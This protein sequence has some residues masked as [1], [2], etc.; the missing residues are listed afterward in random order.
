MPFALRI[1][2][3]PPLSSSVTE[4]VPEAR[5][6]AADRKVVVTHVTVTVETLA[7]TVPIP[8]MTVHVCA[9]LPAASTVTAY[10]PP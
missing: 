2:L 9:G 10:V 1:S 5:D 6:R 7:V 4:S 8:P 3:S